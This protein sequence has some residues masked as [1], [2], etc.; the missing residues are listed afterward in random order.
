MCDA[1]RVARM[2]DA[3]RVARMCDAYM[4]AM[5]RSTVYSYRL[6]SAKEPNE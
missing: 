2:C 6:L 5:M 4:V 3:C 1:Y